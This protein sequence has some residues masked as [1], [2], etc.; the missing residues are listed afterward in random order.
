MN[1]SMFQ[2]IG[3][4]LHIFTEEELM[5]IADPDSKYFLEFLILHF[6]GGLNAFLYMYII[7]RYGN[8]SFNFSMFILFSIQFCSLHK[9]FLKDFL[10]DFIFNF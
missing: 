5:F 2:K 7:D 6:T 9:Y 3:K 1:Y 8:L 4:V 10:S